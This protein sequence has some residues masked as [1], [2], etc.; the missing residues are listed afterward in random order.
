MPSTQSVDRKTAMLRR[1]VIDPPIPVLAQGLCLRINAESLNA[2]FALLLV[3]HGQT[4][5]VKECKCNQWRKL[6]TNET[7]SGRE[8][9]KSFTIWPRATLARILEDAVR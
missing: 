4:E 2:A 1:N 8:S 6:E 9:P 3:L 7:D 5:S